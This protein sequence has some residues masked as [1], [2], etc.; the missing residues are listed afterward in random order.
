MDDLRGTPL[1]VGTLEEMIDE[2]HAIVSSAGASACAP[3]AAPARAPAWAPAGASPACSRSQLRASPSPPAHTHALYAHKIRA[4]LLPCSHAV[5]PEYYV[6]IM[7]F[8]DKTQ[9]EPGSTVL[10]HNKVRSV[11]VWMRACGLAGAGAGASASAA[12]PRPPGPCRPPPA[13]FPPTGRLLASRSCS[14][15]C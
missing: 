12:W 15:S 10:L 11:G 14:C 7:S 8:V 6:T 1:S 9:L 4:P 5:G 3:Q 2:N 13:T